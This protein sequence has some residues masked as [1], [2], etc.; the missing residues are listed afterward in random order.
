MSNAY[1]D[2]S[3]FYDLLGWNIFARDA[4]IRLR[5]F[6]KIRGETPDTI[7]DLACGTGELEKALFKTGIAFTGVDISSGMIKIARGKNPGVKFIVSDAAKVRLN[8]QFDMVL[9]LFDSANHMHSLSH[10][11]AVFRN[12]RRHLRPGGYFIFDFLTENGLEEWEQINIRRETNYTLFY[13]GHYYPEK[14][15]A[16]IF[17]EAFIKSQKQ[18]GYRRIFQ[19]LVEKT[20]PPSDI[21]NGLVKSGFEKI[22]ASP[23]DI[24][25]KIEKARRLWFVCQQKA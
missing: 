11:T 19:K 4:A 9:L 13:Y 20:Y 21:I 22:M 12:A 17:I 8:Y 2:F 1:G 3:E 10:L 14:L 15:L 6:F 25:E 18:G 7:L 23:Y 24:D 16:D 5:S